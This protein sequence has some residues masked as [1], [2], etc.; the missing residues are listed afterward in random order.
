MTNPPGL[1][2]LETEKQ[3]ILDLLKEYEKGL[4]FGDDAESRDS[5]EEEADE[6]EEFATYLGVKQVLRKRLARIER[7]LTLGG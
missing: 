1:E 3:K 7:Q 4:D 6:A 2:Q 5:F